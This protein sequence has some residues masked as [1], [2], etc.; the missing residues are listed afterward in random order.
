MRTETSPTSRIKV[1]V[2]MQLISKSMEAGETNGPTQQSLERG[3][4]LLKPLRRHAE[5]R[6]AR[7]LLK[8]GNEM[9]A[10][11]GDGPG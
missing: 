9:P 11:A 4:P 5:D 2:I 6:T 3:V 1:T 10:S 7:A 8:K